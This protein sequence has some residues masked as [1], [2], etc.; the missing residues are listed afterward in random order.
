[1]R[2]FFLFKIDIAIHAYQDTQ[3][4]QA[5]DIQERYER[6]KCIIASFDICNRKMNRRIDRHKPYCIAFNCFGY[7]NKY[8]N[9]INKH[10]KQRVKQKKKKEEESERN[11]RKVKVWNEERVK[12]KGKRRDQ[13]EEKENERGNESKS[14]KE[15]MKLCP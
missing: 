12:D 5:K 6:F 14:Y 13:K 2:P 15:N 4:Q 8:M 7:V 10:I 9:R 3:P 11:N 1:M